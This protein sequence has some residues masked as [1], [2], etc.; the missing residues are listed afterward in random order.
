MGLEAEAP[1]GMGF[2]IVDGAAGI[3]FEPRTIHGLKEKVGEIP[4][5][6]LLGLD[7]D[8]GIDELELIAGLQAD[9]ITGFGADA[10]PIDTCGAGLGAIGLY[11]DLDIPGMKL[12]Y[13]WLV[14]LE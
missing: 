3:L 14:E 10:Q 12:L 9:L 8:L 4:I 5:L 7:G 2:A 6:H 1:L 13:K 11:G